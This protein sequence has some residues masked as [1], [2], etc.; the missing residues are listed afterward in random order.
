MEIIAF[1]NGIIQMGVIWA[2]KT[3]VNGASERAVIITLAAASWLLSVTG[4]LLLTVGAESLLNAA[5]W[6]IYAAIGLAMAIGV[7]TGLRKAPIRWTWR[8]HRYEWK[9]SRAAGARQRAQQ[10]RSYSGYTVV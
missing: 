4:L 7:V 3:K 9:T 6:L 2:A 1:A 5:A 10:R 8:P